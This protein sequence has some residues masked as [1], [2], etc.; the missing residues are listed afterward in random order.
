M[1]IWL[2]IS[3]TLCALIPILLGAAAWPDGGLDARP[4]TRGP[5]HHFYGYIGHVQNIPWSGNGRYIAT[6]RTG[7]QDHM[8]APGE[9]ADIVLLD[10]K[11][12]YAERVVEQTRAWNFQQGTMLYWN[13]S[14]PDSELF[15]NDRDPVTN[16]VFTVRFDI[17]LGKRVREYRFPD[18]P[19][20]NSGVAQTG[21]YFLG[22]NY[23]R[24][25]RL[26]PVT[27]YPEVFD[28]TDGV[29]H[30]EDDGIFKVDIDTGEKRLLVSYHQLA[31]A[32]RPY[33]PDVDAKA[34][35]INHTLGNRAGDR[36]YFFVRGDF[37]DKDR[38]DVPFT[39]ES[40]GAGLTL[41]QA[42]IGGHPEWAEGHLLIGKQ[43]AEQV[44]YDSDTQTVVSVLGDASVF[45]NPG[46]DVAL[47]P[48]GQWLVNGYRTGKANS[49]VFLNR[50]TRAVLRAGPFPVDHWTSGELR[51]DGAPCWNRESSAVVFPAI[52]N[53]AERTRQMFL[54]EIGQLKPAP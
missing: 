54:V 50:K 52:A 1:A 35:F 16:Q 49:Y 41:H 51:I 3:H 24:L 27:G 5:A 26:R 37:E 48:D 20:A 7:F 42:H 36:I 33:R 39:I 14:A 19:F 17:A 9:A 10:T 8:P 2:R 38:L 28:W 6:L 21:G 12:G 32:L 15:F 44:L 45:P 29:L 43:G 34:L 40:D 46:G 25:A 53:D 11:N 13:P 47:S 30:P 31:E 23:G 18:T 22:L 4:I